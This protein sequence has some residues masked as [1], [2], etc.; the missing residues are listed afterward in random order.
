MVSC[1]DLT[2]LCAL[3]DCDCD[4]VQPALLKAA[5]LKGKAA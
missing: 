5:G 4:R 1:A 2:D 3:A